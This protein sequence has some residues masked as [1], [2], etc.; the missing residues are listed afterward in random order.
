MN[1]QEKRALVFLQKLRRQ[2]RKENKEY[3]EWSEAM[4]AWEDR[5]IGKMPKQLEESP[6]LTYGFYGNRTLL[7]QLEK[8]LD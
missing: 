8:L 5:P 4:R 6:V 7:R 2:L 3:L 1:S